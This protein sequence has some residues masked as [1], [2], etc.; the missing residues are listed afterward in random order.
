MRGCCGYFDPGFASLIRPTRCAYHGRIAALKGKFVF[1]DLVSGRVFVSDVAAMKKADDGIPQTVAPVEVI[2][3]YIRDENGRRADVS[4]LDLIAR[5]MGTRTPR[6]DLHI[7]IS[8][9]GELFLTSR[10]TA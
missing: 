4:L 9:D 2:Q 8:G 7:S 10:R 6:A 1:G 5:A 3:L